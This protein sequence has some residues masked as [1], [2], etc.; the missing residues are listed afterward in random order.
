MEGQSLFLFSA[1][2]GIGDGGARAIHSDIAATFIQ[3]DLASRFIHHLL[4]KSCREK[5]RRASNNL[6]E[7]WSKMSIHFLR[8]WA[9]HEQEQCRNCGES[10]TRTEVLC[11]SFIIASLRIYTDRCPSCTEQEKH[12]RVR[13]AAPFW[14]ESHHLSALSSPKRQQLASSQAI[15]ATRTNFEKQSIFRRHAWCRTSS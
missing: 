5:S 6:W 10:S 1:R 11:P 12:N 8:A 2:C 14:K 4:I 13:K 15:S 9:V 7:N 3:D